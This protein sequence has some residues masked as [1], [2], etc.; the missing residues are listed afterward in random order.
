VP[1]RSLIGNFPVSEHTD[2][3]SLRLD[4]NFTAT[5]R[6]MLRGG[7]SPSDQTGIQV[8]A[9]GPQNFGQNAFSRTSTQNYHDWSITAQDQLVFGN[10]INEFNFQYAR[11]GLLYSFS[12][13]PGGSDVAVNI[14]GFAF[15]GREPFSFVNRTEKRFQFTD[16][17]SISKNMHT[18]K[19]GGDVNHLPVTADFTVNFGGIYNFGQ[20][21]PFPD[22]FP[23]FS[24]IQAYGGG[25]PSNFIQGVGGPHDSF[26]NTTLGLFVQDSWRIKPNLTLNYGVRYDVEFTPTFKAIN[27]T[28]EFGQ[29][30]LGVTQG[31]PRDNDNF[32]PRIGLAWDPWSDHKTAIRASY[33]I[34]YDHPLLALAFDSDVADGAQ[35]PQFVLFGGAP[36]NAL[37][38]PNPLSL[39]AA[40]TFQGIAGGANCTPP[41]LTTAL[42][43]LANEQRFN[44]APNAPS[45][46][47][48]QE[49]LQAG[50][51]LV[52]QP[53][54]FPTAS[55]FRYAYSQ[56]GNFAIDR[57]LGHNLALSVEYSFN[58]GHHL[59]RPINP[60]ATKGNLLV[61]NYNVAVAAGAATPGNSIGPLT[62][63]SG[64]PPCGVNANP[65]PLQG[66][67][68]V[69]A[70]L[71][72]FFRPSG[73]NPSLANFLT[74]VGAGSC[75]G[76][77][78]QILAGVGLNGSCDAATLADCVPFSDMPAN[79]SNGNSV[80]HALT[81]NLRKKFSHHYELLASYTWSHAIDDSTDLQSPLSPQDNYDPGAE[82]SNSLFDQ[83]HRFVFSAVYQSGKL[84]G[85][86]FI[87]KFFSDWTIAPL[88]EAVSG[89]P[90]NIIVGDDRNFDF[91]TSTDRPLTVASGTAKNSCGDTP[92][93][94]A[95]SPTGFFQPACFLD[96]TLIGNLGRNAGTKPYDLFT[97]IGISKNIPLGERAS[98]QGRV[99]V[100]NLINRFNVA[101][102]NP[103]W[104]SGQKPTASFDQRQIQFALKVQW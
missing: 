25:I 47:V 55:D 97:D 86:G 49:Y 43:F 34:F 98:L 26:S 60:N 28:A 78:N 48:N 69:S 33:G 85:S 84:G 104:D 70:A 56:Q 29:N 42:N 82:R 27:G 9:Q 17:F 35:A 36:C 13:G 99:D 21:A 101:D 83:R 57:D 50:V 46:F 89:R 76:L 81:A 65:G 63:G 59:N 5:N 68:W 90:F 53:F 66:Q 44:P 16:N 52:V 1:L 51:P 58:G 40:N 72:S 19:F 67:P 14:P 71:V 41:G 22:P 88:I 87:R 94:S 6:L 77:A 96:G 31:I 32:A 12:R 62:V 100:F 23:A 8:Q 3:Y 64:N 54:G 75:V 4:H 11:R 79:Y 95:F 91:G 103:L 18:F 15:F 10:K 45:A 61:N 20:Q 80:Y 39:N 30:F 2:L 38:A 24:P 74:A 102:V 93:P 73:L 7:F 92:A 37:S